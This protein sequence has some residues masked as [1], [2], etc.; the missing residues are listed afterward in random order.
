MGDDVGQTFFVFVFVFDDDEY[1]GLDTLGE[2]INDHD[3]IFYFPWSYYFKELSHVLPHLWL[4][5]SL[6]YK[7]E[8]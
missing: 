8:G 5:V 4:I 6:P 7:R 3:Q 1:I 2:H